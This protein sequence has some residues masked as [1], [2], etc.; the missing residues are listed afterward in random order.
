MLCLLSE[1]HHGFVLLL[2][3]PYPIFT[4]TFAQKALAAMNKMKDTGEEEGILPEVLLQCVVKALTDTS[5]RVRITAAIA[6]YTLNRPNE[7]VGNQLKLSFS[8]F[9]TLK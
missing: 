9:L 6:L 4:G 2:L 5:T 3:P 8:W 7:E 1:F